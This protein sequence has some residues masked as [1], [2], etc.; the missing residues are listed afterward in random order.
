M[1]GGKREIHMVVTIQRRRRFAG[2]CSQM[3]HNTGH[4]EMKERE[5][6]MGIAIQMRRVIF[7]GGVYP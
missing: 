1:G 7:K 4:V 5:I 2:V 3:G 6:H